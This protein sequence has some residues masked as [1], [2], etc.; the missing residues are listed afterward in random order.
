V[1]ISP[2]RAG[3]EARFLE[4]R[5]RRLLALRLRF[6]PRPILP[7]LCEPCRCGCLPCCCR[8]VPCCGWHPGDTCHGPSP[9]AI[10]LAQ[11]YAGTLARMQSFDWQIV[12]GI[13]VS[14]GDNLGAILDVRV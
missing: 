8:P 2:I 7:V 13:R 1:R 9:A 11:A 10:L 4:N 12:H 3:T 5:E 14:G 6:C